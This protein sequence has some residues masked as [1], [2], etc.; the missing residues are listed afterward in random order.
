MDFPDSPSVGATVNNGISTWAW[1][2]KQ[3]ERASAGAGGGGGGTD[4]PNYR[5]LRAG[6][7]AADLGFVNAPASDYR[8]TSGSPLRGVGTAVGLTM[9]ILGNTVPAVPDIGAFQF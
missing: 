3:W 4:S 9:D 1:N 6:A 5:Y 2:G 7:P 8:L